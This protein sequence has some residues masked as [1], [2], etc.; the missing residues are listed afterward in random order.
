M[1]TKKEP[2]NEDLAKAFASAKP[3]NPALTSADKSYLRGLLRRGFTAEEI[4]TVAKNAGFQ[5][6]A[7]LFT[8]RKKAAA[9][10]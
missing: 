9:K 10:A 8:P 2:V 5:V 4:Q 1:A 3:A 7:E 6:T